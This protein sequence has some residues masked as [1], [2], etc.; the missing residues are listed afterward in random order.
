MPSRIFLVSNNNNNKYSAFVC[1]TRRKSM[2]HV[3]ICFPHNLNNKSIFHLVVK[4]W[5]F[6]RF[7]VPKMVSF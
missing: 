3:N 6:V 7:L 4:F 1:S 2:R 5:V